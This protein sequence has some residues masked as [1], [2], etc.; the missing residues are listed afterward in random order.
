MQ[1]S[2]AF[3]AILGSGG[4]PHGTGRYYT[5]PTGDQLLLVQQLEDIRISLRMLRR[6]QR[7]N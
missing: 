4:H 3:S 5:A 1:A 2:N 6:Y 7:E